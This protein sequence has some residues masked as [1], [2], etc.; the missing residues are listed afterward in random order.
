MSDSNRRPLKSRGSKW[1]AALTTLAGSNINHAQPDIHG[2][3]RDGSAR[4]RL[5]LA[6]C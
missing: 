2:E 1:A 6:V 5:I 3:H 4:R